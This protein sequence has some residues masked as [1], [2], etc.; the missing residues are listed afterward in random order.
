MEAL[1]YSYYVASAGLLRRRH[2]GA[3]HASRREL[4]GSPRLSHVIFR[5]SVDDLSS[6]MANDQRW[7]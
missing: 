7:A 3:T 5:T 6:W 4:F 2:Q 1:G